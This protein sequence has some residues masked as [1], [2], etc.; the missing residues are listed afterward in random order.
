MKMVRIMFLLAAVAGLTLAA[1]TPVRGEEAYLEKIDTFF[2][3]LAAGKTDEAVDYIYAG[4][5]WIDTS[6]DNVKNVK[7]QLKSLGQLV[8]K[9]RD[10]QK[11]AT[12]LVA[13]RFI[14]LCYFVAYDRQPFQFE[15]EF[16]RPGDEGMIFSFSFDADI[17]DEIA[18]QAREQLFQN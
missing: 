6:A 8:G 12:S 10:H 7:S 18:E 15:F 13:G 5:P 1:G 3:K 16:Y 17:D 4:N 9:Y 11:M 14:Y 2:E